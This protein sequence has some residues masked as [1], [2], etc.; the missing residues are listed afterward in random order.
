[1][2][3]PVL[4]KLGLLFTTC[5]LTAGIVIAQ[6]MGS[7]NQANSSATTAN[8]KTSDRSFAKEA[9][10]GGTAEVKLGKL[11]EEKGHVAPV[12]NFGKRMV[13]DHSKAIKKLES[14]AS[15][16][17]ISIPQKMSSKEQAAYDRL[18]KLTG[19]AFDHAYAHLMVKDHEHD[20]AAFRQEAENGQKQPI[21]NFAS[22]TLPV[23]EHH[24]ALA[25]QM[26]QELQSGSTQ[27]RST[28]AA[29]VAGSR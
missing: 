14:A 27:S 29:S 12:R 2:R 18:S 13:N 24:L 20:V 10:E 22:N 6:R 17:N 21:K 1:M 5:F 7:S 4:R 23:L 26:N 11:A 9:A 25:R 8:R 15:Q 16:A 19:L 28:S 3:N